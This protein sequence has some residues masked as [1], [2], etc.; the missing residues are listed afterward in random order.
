MGM[1]RQTRECPKPKRPPLS[2]EQRPRDRVTTGL[3]GVGT[4][5]PVVIL[6]QRSRPGLVPRPRK[7]ISQ[8]REQTSC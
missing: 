1:I 5:G 4:G 6:A 7:N 8:G 2:K 3:R